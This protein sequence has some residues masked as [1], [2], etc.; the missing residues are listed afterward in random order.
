MKKILIL[1]FVVFRM[2]QSISIYILC[3]SVC[4]FVCLFVSNKRQISW[5]E[6]NFYAGHH[7]TQGK[8][9]GWSKF[10]KLASNKIRFSLNFENPQN[11]FYKVCHFFFT[12]YTKKKMFTIEI[13]DWRVAPLKS[14]LCILCLSFCS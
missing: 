7:M 10:Q 14:S 3:L 9:Y 5:I 8:V 11:I 12:I 13:E 4:L 1:Q 6:F 2:V